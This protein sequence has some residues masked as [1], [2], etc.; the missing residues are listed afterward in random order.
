[1]SSNMEGREHSRGMDKIG[2]RH[3]NE[4]RRPV[5]MQTLQNN[6][7]PKPCGKGADDSVIGEVESTEGN[8]LIRRTSWI[9]ESQEYRAPK[10]DPEVN[11]RQSKT[12]GE[13]H[14]ELVY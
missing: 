14:Y 10:S 9:Q 13:P 3:I 7:T 8:A 1:M 4:D 6:G 5:S 11:C 2:Q 12:K